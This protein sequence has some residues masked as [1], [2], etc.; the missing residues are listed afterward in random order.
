M[1]NGSSLEQTRKPLASNGSHILG[2][3]YRDYKRF[4]EIEK[5]NS[6][7]NTLQQNYSQSN[8]QNALL[9]TMNPYQTQPRSDIQNNNFNVRP[10]SQMAKKISTPITN[11]TLSSTLNPITNSSDLLAEVQNLKSLVNSLIDNQNQIQNKLIES[12]K[13]MTEQDNIIR[14]NHVKLT[15]HDNKI[16][17]ILLSFNNY[18]QVNEKTSKTINEM[19][20]R[21]DDLV[22]YDDFNTLK[23][24]VFDN[25]TISES[26]FKEI[27]HSFDDV[28]IKMNEIQKENENYQKFTLDKISTVQKEAMELRLQTQNELIKMEESKEQRQKAQI[29]QIKGMVLM[30]DSNLK[31]ETE[32]RKKM[33]NSLKEEIYEQLKKYEDGTNELKKM[34]L[35]TE[36]N[37]IYLSK[38]YMSTFN[39]LITKHNEKYNIELKTIRSIIEAGLTK[40][41]MKMDKDQKV[42][43]DNINNIHSEMNEIKSNVMNM[44]AYVKESITNMESKY[45][46]CEEEVNNNTIKVNLVSDT[47]DKFMGEARN[48]INSKNEETILTLKKNL[49][50]R[51]E[52]MKK[53]EKDIQDENNKKFIDLNDKVDDINANL[54]VMKLGGDE[55]MKKAIFGI[56]S[57]EGE[58]NDMD[59]QNSKEPHIELIREFCLKIFSD[60]IAPYQKSL[61]DYEKKLNTLLIEK[62]DETRKS[63]NEEQKGNIDKYLDLV[64]KKLINVRDTIL[65][66]IEDEKVILDGKM[67]EYILLNRKDLEKCLS[68]IYLTKDEQNNMSLKL[69]DD[70]NNLIAKLGI[71][72]L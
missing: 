63:I 50:E 39:D 64:D 56:G 68:E 52:E 48:L 62:L 69:M 60:R 72:G 2:D 10:L 47:L 6:G 37:L 21:F 1:I 27:F 12:N 9:N 61:E 43:V 11:P 30:L 26:K 58:Y 3:N 19:Q 44:D 24:N 54:K 59:I 22:K 49:D 65:K 41:D 20:S 29:E 36:Q 28:G 16:T 8:L 40:V 25:N 55:G 5:M 34:Q 32:F 31:E 7:N 71:S 13:I 14:V 67:Q 38:D 33:I 46:T 70:Y 15:D 35:E 45:E 57:K 42:F 4:L 66:K 18:L 17:E 51:I 53:E 23:E